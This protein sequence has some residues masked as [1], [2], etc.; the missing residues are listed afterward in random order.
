MSIDT[1]NKA[2]EEIKEEMSKKEVSLKIAKV[3]ECDY[4]VEIDRI[5]QAIKTLTKDGH[6]KP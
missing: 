1:K 6:P 5:E 2:L 4:L 3:K